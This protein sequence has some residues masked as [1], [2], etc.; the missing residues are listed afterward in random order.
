MSVAVTVAFFGSAGFRPVGGG[1]FLAAALA[2]A[3]L[4]AAAEGAGAFENPS[5]QRTAFELESGA[6]RKSFGYHSFKQGCKI[7]RST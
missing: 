2:A 1:A 6:L 3:T 4:L 5:T 7:L